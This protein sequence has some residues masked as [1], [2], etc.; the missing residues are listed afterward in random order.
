MDQ[1]AAEQGVRPEIGAAEFER[2]LHTTPKQ[3]DSISCGVCV[4]IEIQRIAEGGH[5]LAP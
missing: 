4:L 1:V 3:P 2:K 5:R